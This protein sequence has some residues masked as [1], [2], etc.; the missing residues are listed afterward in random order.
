MTDFRQSDFWAGWRF[1]LR[2]H[3]RSQ[4]T[5]FTSD[6]MHAAFEVEQLRAGGAREHDP[7]LADPD[8]P[9]SRLLV[10]IGRRDP[11][12]DWAV[13]DTPTGVHA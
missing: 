5:D 8:G 4:P 10:G 2:S 12:W 6:L 3:D 1:K 11:E 7:E 9:L 13:G